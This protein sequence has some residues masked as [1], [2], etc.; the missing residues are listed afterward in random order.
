MCGVRIGP[1]DHDQAGASGQ[2]VRDGLVTRGLPQRYGFENMVRDCVRN[3]GTETG[4]TET[5]APAPA[6]P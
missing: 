2:E 5:T 4:P 6:T 1:G 3:T